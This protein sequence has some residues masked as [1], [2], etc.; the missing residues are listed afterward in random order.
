MRS[1]VQRSY[2]VIATSLLIS[3]V[4]EADRIAQALKDEGWP[5]ANRSL[6]IREA[7]ALI[8]EALR[9]KNSEEIFRYFIDRRGRR[10]PYGPKS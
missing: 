5:A 6:V 10:I 9:G 8:A 1:Q 2:H 4:A 3:D 7:V